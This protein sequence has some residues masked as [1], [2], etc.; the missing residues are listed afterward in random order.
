[1][2]RKLVHWVDR[3][4]NQIP[5]VVVTFLSIYIIY[6]FGANIESKSIP[7]AMYAVIFCHVASGIFALE[8]DYL[9]SLTKSFTFAI[10]FVVCTLILVQTIIGWPFIPSLL[11]ISIFAGVAEYLLLQPEK[12]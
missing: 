8:D 9:N 11:V 1:M 5:A 6:V 2:F 12:L 4:A 10:T 7:Y 3:Y